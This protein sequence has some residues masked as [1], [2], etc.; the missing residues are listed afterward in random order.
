MNA[1]RTIVFARSRDGRTT[2]QFASRIRIAGHQAVIGDCDLDPAEFVDSACRLWRRWQQLLPDDRC[3]QLVSEVGLV[4]DQDRTRPY[5]IAHAN[6]AILDG[7]DRY[8]AASARPATVSWADLPA[9]A[10]LVLGPSATLALV[11][12]VLDG[13]PGVLDRSDW[14]FA[15]NLVIEDTALSPY[16]PQIGGNS[17]PIRI[18]PEHLACDGCDDGAFM[19]LQRS[20]RWQR[21]VNALYNV[22]RRN[23]AISCDGGHRRSG[24]AMVVID[25]LTAETEPTLAR[26]RWLATW[27]LDQPMSRRWGGERLG[28]AIETGCV[29]QSITAAVG[30]P[31]PA[32][33]CDPIEGEIY[34]TAPSLALARS[35]ITTSMVPP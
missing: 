4:C 19:L 29:L 24:D 16:P 26:S 14:P 28:L 8:F 18:N 32:C 35:A 1:D 34:G 12:F 5:A 10:T 6:G 31:R 21:P 27:H 13:I 33:I 25:T 2:Q 11:D 9:E 30:A 7:D 23:L 20:E 3:G 15:S 17:A 22:R